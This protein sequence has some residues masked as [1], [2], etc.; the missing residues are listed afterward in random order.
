MKLDQLFLFY[1]SVFL[2]SEGTFL[3]GILF[4][5][6]ATSGWRDFSREPSKVEEVD[7]VSF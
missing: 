4:F 6:V 3:E 5:F 1:G 2:I 7:Q